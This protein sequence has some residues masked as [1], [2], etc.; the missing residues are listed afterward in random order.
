M[1]VNPP[2]GARMAAL[3]FGMSSSTSQRSSWQSKLAG[4]TACAVESPT[5]TTKPAFGTTQDFLLYLTLVDSSQAHVHK[6]P[7]CSG[8]LCTTDNTKS[9]QTYKPLKPRD[10]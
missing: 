7:Q 10:L 5:L 8:H 4:P 6:D 3:I 9:P 1:E 2:R